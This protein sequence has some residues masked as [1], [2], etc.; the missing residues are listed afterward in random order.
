MK[1]LLDDLDDLLDGSCTMSM[2]AKCHWVNSNFVND[3]RQLFVIAVFS[4]LLGQIVT[5]WVVHD[6]HEALNG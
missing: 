1:R 3:L 2:T 6:I 5:E 4:Y